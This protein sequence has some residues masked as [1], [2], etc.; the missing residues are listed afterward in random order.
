MHRYLL[1]IVWLCAT[2]SALATVPISG[3][4]VLCEGSTI[5]LSAPAAMI[6]YT[7]NTGATTRAITVGATGHYS[8]KVTT[9]VGNIDSGSVDVTLGYKPRPRIGNPIE[10][11]CEGDQANLEAPTYYSQYLW[12]TGETTSSIRVVSN[13]HYWVTVTDT[14]GCTGQSDKVQV[15]V[16]SKPSIQIT[17]PDA[18]CPGH[19]TPY[20]V[21]PVP[22]TSYQWF[23]DG[24][25]IASGQ[26]TNTIQVQW[27]R[28]GTIRLRATYSRPDGGQCLADTLIRITVSN[29]LRPQLQYASNG[30]CRGD[31]LLL[32]AASGYTSY[33]WSTGATSQTIRITKGG[34]YW[35]IVTDASGC[36]GVTDTL[37]VLDYE[38]PN[39]SIVGSKVVCKG[40]NVV[41]EGVAA[42]NNV[43]LWQWSTGQKGKQIQTSVPGTYSVVGYTMDGCTDTASVTLRDTDPIVVTIAD[44]N[45][46][47]VPTG[48]PITA[49]AMV[50]NQG[51]SDI[52]VISVTPS[53]PAVITPSTPRF[54]PSFRD[55]AFN[56]VYT[57]EVAGAFYLELTWIVMNA[58]CMDTLISVISGEASGVPPIGSIHVS[59][60][61]TTVSLGAGLRLPVEVQWHYRMPTDSGI[62]FK[63]TYPQDAFYLEYVE[64][65]TLISNTVN[66]GN[67]E[68]VLH[69]PSLPGT[70]GTNRYYLVGM[71]LLRSPFTA[72]VNPYGAI[73]TS[74]QLVVFTYTNGSI[75]TTGCWLPARLIQLTGS[76]M[77]LSVYSIQGEL[78][79]QKTLGSDLYTSASALLAEFSLP[80]QP[81]LMRITDANGRIL[82]QELYLTNSISR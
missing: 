72:P 7:W 4:L 37:T 29:R 43:V 71:P 39:V 15:V 22:G 20:A 53:L 26:G 27:N 36:T 80:I 33:L 73:H 56:V 1:A 67:R 35:V 23:C 30:L 61:D 60:P 78:L 8:C 54:I 3:P 76:E 42:E 77:Q 44:V 5:T 6:N 12:S 10:Y 63:V 51:A 21:T 64:G 52:S 65:C 75:T 46:G 25:T 2:T 82:R 32:E 18:V 11:L 41:L 59:I 68:L 24:G 79:V 31:T 62:Q 38:P 14:N 70:A 19:S 69:T 17:G 34:A 47:I 58:D 16:I 48:M 28:T 57:P 13:G 50:Y 74:H 49:L 9:Q 81:V 45:V 66:S 55:Q 40:A